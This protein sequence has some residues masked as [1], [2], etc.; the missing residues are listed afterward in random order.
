MNWLNW[1]VPLFAVFGIAAVAPAWVY[2]V[3]DRLSGLPTHIQFFAGLV[4][5][6]LAALL[7]ASWAE[8]T[9]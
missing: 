5:P 2:F 7:L 1:W 8:P 6:A 3:G 9:R 4:L